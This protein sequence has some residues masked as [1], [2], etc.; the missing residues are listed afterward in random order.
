LAMVS[1]VRRAKLVKRCKPTARA[2][3]YLYSKTQGKRDLRHALLP[4]QL[5]VV[6]TL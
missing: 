6:S 3:T 1:E 5:I 2:I 4:Y